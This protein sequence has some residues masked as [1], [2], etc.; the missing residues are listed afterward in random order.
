[1]GSSGLGEGQVA[2]VRAQCC[3]FEV[4][5]LLCVEVVGGKDLGR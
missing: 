5:G 1:M 2:E 3:C 4:V